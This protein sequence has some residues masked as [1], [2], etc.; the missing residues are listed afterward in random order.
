MIPWFPVGTL[1][2]TEPAVNHGWCTPVGCVSEAVLAQA[3]LAVGVLALVCFALAALSFVPEAR[4]V[5]REE[6]SRAAAERDAFERFRR[7]VESV[8]ATPTS[9]PDGGQLLGGGTLT[10]SRPPDDRLDTVR[11]AYRETVM[12][13]DHY[14]AEYDESLPTNLGAEFGDGVADALEGGQ[15]FSPALRQTLLE[16]ATEASE[17]RARLCRALDS[18]SVTLREAASTLREVEDLLDETEGPTLSESYETLRRRW[19]RLDAAETTLERVV[20]ENQGDIHRGYGVAPR[21]GGPVAL[22]EYLYDSQPYTHPVLAE[23]TQLLDA[24]HAAQDR[25]A[26]AM[27]RRV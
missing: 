2:S 16:G 12:A 1:V 23:S 26:T 25:T 13:V 7:R 5:V 19:D 21:M 6:H 11:D 18:E 8:D 3:F 20:D 4:A 17:R 10:R 22:H 14:E 27:S 24:V 9:L 15:T